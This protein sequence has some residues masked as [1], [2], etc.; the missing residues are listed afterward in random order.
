MMTNHQRARAKFSDPNQSSAWG[1]NHLE[2]YEFVSWDD[3]IPIY[4][5]KDSHILWKKWETY[6]I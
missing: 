4:Y 1:N 2:K 6:S 3:E 5:G